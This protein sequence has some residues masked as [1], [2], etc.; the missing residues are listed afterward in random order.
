[1]KK[2]IGI[3][4]ISVLLLGGLTACNDFLDREPLDKETPEVF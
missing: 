3:L 1:M 4:S 2:H